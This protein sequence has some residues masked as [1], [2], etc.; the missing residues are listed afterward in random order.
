MNLKNKI[1][2]ENSV[3][4]K[5]SIAT[6]QHAYGYDPVGSYA[7][8]NS[9]NLRSEVKDSEGNLRHDIG[10][11]ECSINTNI[12]KAEANIRQEVA[13]DIGDA[14]FQLHDNI[15]VL[16]TNVNNR[17]GLVDVGLVRAEM[18]TKL[19]A[20]QVIKEV[21]NEVRHQAERTQDRL[22]AIDTRLSD[23]LCAFERRVDGGFST[24]SKELAECCC[25][26]KQLIREEGGKGNS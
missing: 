12:L 23:K 3:I 4:T 26:L 21:T 16:G 22:T 1:F 13:K 10:R 20:E 19:S 5:D 9:S 11:A 14:K 25:D 2:M 18:Q 6:T 7:A 24:F 15:S 8:Y 17:F